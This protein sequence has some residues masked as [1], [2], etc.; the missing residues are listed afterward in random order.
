MTDYVADPKICAECSLREQ[1][2]RG[3]KLGRSVAR[4]WKEDE[5]IAAQKE[6]HT[7]QAFAARR[8]RRHLMEGSF[9]QAA[10]RHHFKRAR[11]RR[12]WRQQ[13]QDWIIAAVQNI[14]ILGREQGAGVA[15]RHRKPVG[16]ARMGSFVRSR[17]LVLAANRRV[18]NLH[19]RGFP[20]QASGRI[21][22]YLP[23]VLAGNVG[24]QALKV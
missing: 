9:A 23:L 18:S 2:T 13:I 14:A 22:Y 19:S 6:A 12:L 1:C 7:P 5:L 3:K 8:R 16:P 15:A 10:N 21:T 11:W 24:Q 17:R 20:V 4:H